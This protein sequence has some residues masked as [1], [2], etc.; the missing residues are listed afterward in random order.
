MAVLGA[1][2]ERGTGDG[3][4]QVQE[5]DGSRETGDQSERS[6]E[7]KGRDSRGDKVERGGHKGC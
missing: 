2:T 1:A 7:E 4:R 3:V 5:L 6:D